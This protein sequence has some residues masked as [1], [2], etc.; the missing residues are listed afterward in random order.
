MLLV[1]FM[2]HLISIEMVVSCFSST[3]NTALSNIPYQ[4]PA[5]FFNQQGCT[6]LETFLF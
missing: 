2:H 6:I 5:P 1:Y 3:Y 4:A